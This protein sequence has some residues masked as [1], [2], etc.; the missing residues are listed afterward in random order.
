[1]NKAISDNDVQKLD[2]SRESAGM[3][4][5]TAI[6]RRTASAATAATVAA[7]ALALYDVSTPLSEANTVVEI[8]RDVCADTITMSAMDM[9]RKWMRQMGLTEEEIAEYCVDAQY[10]AEIEEERVSLDAMERIVARDA[11]NSAS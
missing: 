6:V 8:H 9:R 11:K 2:I 7:S 1:M 5:I 10:P 3:F 4:A